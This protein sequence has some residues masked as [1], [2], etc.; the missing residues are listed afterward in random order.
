[1][2]ALR[3]CTWLQF[4]QRKKRAIFRN[5]QIDKRP[6]GIFFTIRGRLSQSEL[7]LVP[8]AHRGQIPDVY[9]AIIGNHERRFAPHA[10]LDDVSSTRRLFYRYE[11][12]RRSARQKSRAIPTITW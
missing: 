3:A 9:R 7:F 5:M 4:H 8:L 2:S 12:V 6:P 11:E 10:V 1:M